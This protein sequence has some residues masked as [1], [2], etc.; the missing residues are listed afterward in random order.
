[1]VNV[2]SSDFVSITA[3]VAFVVSLCFLMVGYS[4]V[5]GLQFMA[6]LLTGLHF[7]TCFNGWLQSC[8][9][10]TVY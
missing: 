5:L 1:M 7:I 8:V 4:L 10:V 6:C 9:R 3:F 2:P